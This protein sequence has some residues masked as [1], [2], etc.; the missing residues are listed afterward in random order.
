MFSDLCLGAY[1]MPRTVF[2]TA[3]IVLALAYIHSLDILYRDLKPDNILLDLHGYI[4]LADMGAAR[5][6]AT[7]GFV[8]GYNRESVSAA[9]TAHIR[10][11]EN[12]RQRRM[13]ITGTHGYRAPEVYEREYGKAADWWN[14]GIL[15][16]EMLTQINPLRGDNRKESEHL[17]KTMEVV[18][19]KSVS[20]STTS[21]V[22]GFLQ[23]DSRTRLACG[24]ENSGN[25][26]EA[27]KSHP[28][29][30][31]PKIDWVA[32]LEKKHEV[33]F[34][35]TQTNMRQTPLSLQRLLT[36]ET[37]Q[38]DYFSQTV[39]YM[40]TSITL[41]KSWVLS[42]VEQSQ[43]EGFEYVSASAIEEELDVWNHTA[44]P[45]LPSSNAWTSTPWTGGV[46]GHNEPEVT[47]PMS[48]SGSTITSNSAQT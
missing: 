1:S 3:Q 37:N 47:P 20:A 25:R 33:P 23:K 46:A 39:D 15:I 40:A 32:L 45:R 12:S 28:F 5:G 24:D 18:L 7:D 16:V 43:F 27:V 48:I 14:V 31:E 44:N 34:D 38:I 21:I 4:K 29:F 9:K 30:S 19:P 10:D 13:T 35:V 6:T 11:G 42:P 17:T 2:Y 22:E 36:P 41:R 8:A 26:V